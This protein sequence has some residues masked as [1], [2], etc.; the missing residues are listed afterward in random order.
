MVDTHTHLHG[1]EFGEDIAQILTDMRSK[2]IRA[3]T[4]GTGIEESKQAIALAEQEPSIWASVGVHPH[5][6]LKVSVPEIQEEFVQLSNHPRVVGIGEGGFDF[7]YNNREESYEAQAALFRMHIEISKQ[8]SKPLIIHTRDSFEET[9]EVLSEYQGL[10]II[11]HCFT[12]GPEWV[13]KFQD[14]NHDIYFSFSGIVTFKN[15]VDHIKDSA[16]IIPDSNILAETD[17]PYLAPVPHRGKKNQTP[18][19]WYVIDILAQLRGVS[20][21]E[22]DEQ[23]DRNAERVF[24][25]SRERYQ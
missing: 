4:I 2:S 21:D 16:K 3:V 22:M 17:S 19:V 25:I 6:A 14:L 7:Y 12:G 24:G 1:D 5:E 18:Y 13:E 23:L 10:T 15:N 9:I 8:L 11:L 20:F